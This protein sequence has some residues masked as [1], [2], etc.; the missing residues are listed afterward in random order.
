MHTLLEPNAAAVVNVQNEVRQM[1]LGDDINKP[2][3][4]LGG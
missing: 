2:D 4:A 3:V 1:R